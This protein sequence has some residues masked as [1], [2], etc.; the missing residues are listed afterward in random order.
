MLVNG[1]LE[2]VQGSL[3]AMIKKNIF[4]VILEKF[5]LILILFCKNSNILFFYKA[6][7]IIL[8]FLRTWI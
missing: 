2:A 7:I 4:A 8:T 1:N 5:L 3:G 6:S